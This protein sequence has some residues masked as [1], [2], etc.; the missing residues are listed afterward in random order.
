[1]SLFELFIAYKYK[2]QGFASTLYI[3]KYK[4]IFKLW[5]IGQKF[6]REVVECQN[7]C[8]R[9]CAYI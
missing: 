7:E 9:E 3:Y 5:G 8:V 1:M 4:R 6:L 2:I